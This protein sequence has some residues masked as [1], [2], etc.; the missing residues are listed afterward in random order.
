ME[1]Y[2]ICAGMATEIEHV[3]KS[4]SATPIPKLYGVPQK[5]WSGLHQKRYTVQSIQVHFVNLF[6]RTFIILWRYTKVIY[7]GKAK[8][9]NISQTSKDKKL[10][11]NLGLKDTY[12]T[13]PFSEVLHVS[14]TQSIQELIVFAQS[15][16]HVTLILH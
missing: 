4:I 7:R 9:Y 10:N 13:I 16:E 3:C 15:S 2:K 6:S 8:V 11:T 1:H 14:G 12:E 5:V